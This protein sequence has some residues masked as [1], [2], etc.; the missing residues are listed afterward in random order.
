MSSRPWGKTC[1]SVGIHSWVG[2]CL[3]ARFLIIAVFWW[4]NTR[5]DSETDTQPSAVALEQ[6]ASTSVACGCAVAVFGRCISCS[7]ARNSPHRGAV[8]L[9]GKRHVTS[10]YMHRC[11]VGSPDGRGCRGS[12]SARVRARQSAHA[13]TSCRGVQT[14]R[15]NASAGISE[16]AV[17]ATSGRRAAP[18]RAARMD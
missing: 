7:H 5:Q 17:G 13:R 10:V 15:R 6:D 1:V 4:R 2:L 16:N 11:W 14:P 12:G 3:L 18:S 9:V 8:A